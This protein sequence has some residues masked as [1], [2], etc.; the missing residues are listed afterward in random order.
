MPEEIRGLSVKFDADFSEFKKGMR[1]ADKDISSTQRQLK[2]LQDSLKLEWDPKKFSS[3][4]AQAQKALEATEKKAS[5]LRERLSAMESEGVTD[6]TRSEYNYLAEQLSKTELNAQ[7][8][9]KTLEDLDKMRVA[10]LTRGLDDLSDKLDKAAA[11]TAGLSRAAAATIAG[12]T[13]LGLATVEQADNIATLATK[14]DMSTEALQRFNYVA[15]QTDTEAENLYKAFVKVQGGVADLNTG[16]SSVATKA[17]Q[18]LGISF[19]QFT[20]SEDQFYAI[21]QALSEL[22]DQSLMVSTANDLFGEKLATNLFPLIYAGTDAINDYREEFALMGALTDEQISQLSEFDN[23]LNQVKTQF[24]NVGLQLG[25]AL[26]PVLESFSTM[27]MN[28]ILP[29]L[30]EAAEWFSELDSGTQK[31]LLGLLAVVA[32]LSPTLKGI[33]NLTGGIS[34]LIK[35]VSALDVATLKLYGKWALLAASVGT[36][37]AVIANWSQMNTVQKVI[38]LLGALSAAALAAAVAFGAFHS[39]WSIGMAVAGIVAGIA[40]AT[41]AIAQAGKD[42]GSEVSFDSGSYEAAIS[43]P[44]YTIPSGT[45]TPTSTDNSQTYND[46]SSVTVNIEKNEYMS[47]EDIIRAVNRGLKQARQART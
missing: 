22:E 47:E 19:D 42:I 6:K 38:S 24:K 16:V 20:G 40:T 46:Y 8:L 34:T 29:S 27:L 44:S 32:V 31:L 9:K 4:Q 12:V 28:S 10:N 18:K 17:L 45:T 15:L 39:A 37:L 26:L 7:R 11:K 33:S 21:I 35:W 25:S 5:L 41:A 36:L 13:A 30:Q 23:V 2:N 1:D 43:N 3:A 14:Y